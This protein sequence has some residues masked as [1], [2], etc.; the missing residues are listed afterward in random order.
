MNVLKI[1]QYVCVAVG[2]IGTLLGIYNNTVDQKNNTNKAVEKHFEEEAKKE[3]DN[4]NI[5]E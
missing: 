2:G 3:N 4:D 5:E 1:L